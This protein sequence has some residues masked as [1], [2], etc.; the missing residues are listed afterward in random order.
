ME[1][2]HARV[3]YHS[4]MARRSKPIFVSTGIMVVITSGFVI[5][6]VSRVA[7][8]AV[9]SVVVQIAATVDSDGR[10]P[11]SPAGESGRG[12]DDGPNNGRVRAGDAITYSVEVGL[13]DPTTAT[14]ARYPV[15]VTSSTLPVG[16]TF[17]S[18]PAAC[19]GPDSELRNDNRVL[20]CDLGSRATGS[21]AGFNA[22]VRVDDTVPE[23][24]SI[25]PYFRAT[26]TGFT[27]VA[28]D[29]PPL[30]T[31][32][33]ASP[34]FDLVKNKVTSGIYRAVN[35]QSGYQFDWSYAIRRSRLIGMEPLEST[36]SF[37]E[38]VEDI[39]PGARLI[40]CKNSNSS[41]TSLPRTNNPSSNITTY[42]NATIRQNGTVTCSTGEGAQTVTISGVDWSPTRYPTQTLGG[43][44]IPI[45]EGYVHVGTLEVWIPVGAFT[46]VYVTSRN[47]LSALHGRAAVTRCLDGDSLQP[48]D[49]GYDD[50]IPQRNYDPTCSGSYREPGVGLDAS[51]ALASGSTADDGSQNHWSATLYQPLGARFQKYDAAWKMPASSVPNGVV[52]Y[53]G[54]SRFGSPVGSD[55]R[56]GDGYIGRETTYFSRPNFTGI[57]ITDFDA[58]VI[59]CTTIDNNVV[60]VEPLPGQSE[61]GAWVD[62]GSTSAIVAAAASAGWVVEYGVGGAN[63]SL[64]DNDTYDGRPTW[65]SRDA[66][67][68]G[69][70]ADDDSPV[71]TQ[72]LSSPELAEFGGRWS[73]TKIRF[74]TTRTWTTDDQEIA[75]T[76]RP[77]VF[78]RVRSA[79]A[80]GAVAPNYVNAYVPDVG[81]QWLLATYNATTASGDRGDRI[82]VTGTRVRIA[83]SVDI[84]NVNAGSGTPVNYTLQPTITATDLENDQTSHQVTVVDTLPDGV[85]YVVGSGS[86]SPD[87]VTVNAD[88]TTTI[89]WSLG[90]LAANEAHGAITYQGIV[91]EDVPT[92]TYVNRAVIS[93]YFPGTNQ[94]AANLEDVSN[95]TLRSSTASINVTNSSSF[96]IVKRTLTPRVE[97]GE[98]FSFDV[99]AVNLGATTFPSTT[100]IDWLPATTEPRV[101]KSSFHGGVRLVSVTNNP[102]NA[103]AGGDLASGIVV[104]YT[105]FDP[106]AASFPD[107]ADPSTINGSIGWCT[108]PGA[109]TTNCPATFGDT[110]AIRVSTTTFAPNQRIRI[111]ML[112]EPTQGPSG[113]LGITN[114]QGDVYTNNAVLRRQGTGI[115]LQSNLASVEVGASTLGDYVWRDSDGDGIQSDN[116]SPISGLRVRLY[117]VNPFTNDRTEVEVGPDGILGS[118]DDAAGGIVT[119]SNGRYL[120]TNLP[121]GRYAVRFDTPSR[122]RATRQSVGDDRTVDSD[123]DI[124]GWSVATNLGV[125]TDYL[126]I[127]A[128]FEPLA[129]VTSTST[130]AVTGNVLVSVGSNVTRLLALLVLMITL[131]CA[132]RYN[133]KKRRT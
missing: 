119:D 107:D 78:L 90:D 5:G 105:N 9:T 129:H 100:F 22:V 73:V 35:G 66:Q 55:W 133:A 70:C 124:D 84:T 1:K 111:R 46:D 85:R 54:L 98:Q 51:E 121:H 36:V 52:G 69:T 104:E 6:A 63:G 18:L 58:G 128:G 123:I 38:D 101:A 118:S 72:S 80:V 99:S 7:R 97:V 67:R 65:G 17:A 13:N 131:G 16:F 11:F 27:D 108:T 53:S 44:A 42:P 8:S 125:D 75:G 74:R 2:R 28:T 37:I 56:T 31:A 132:L 19:S 62:T 109:G 33:S 30:V 113:S 86:P 102:G 68:R 21:A 83:K 41:F 76:I 79:A 95:E 34:G 116:E 117:A 50:A 130:T 26:S 122:T 71:W 93:S 25:L 29:V 110:T 39:A 126:H 10:A 87:K 115:V 120:F 23:G 91:D 45:S 47:K 82:T 14:V 3:A 114:R 81:W 64:N 49:V 24:K 103:I 57:G 12:E 77:T 60:E 94:I 40:G 48:N 61:R 32:T 106:N 4:F 15:I 43:S 96:A 20:V 59:L 92:G 112:F 89:K 88:G 127:D